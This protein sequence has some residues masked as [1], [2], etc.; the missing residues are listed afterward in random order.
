MKRTIVA[1]SLR[2]SL[3]ACGVAVVLVV[4]VDWSGRLLGHGPLE[5]LIPFVAVVLAAIGLGAVQPRIDRVVERITHHR[6]VTPY[7]S[8]AAAA[9]RVREGALE[10]ALPGL[11]QVI[12]DG[13]GATKAVVWLVVGD[14]L[15]AAAEHPAPAPGGRT[16]TVENLAVLL[17]RPDVDHAVPVLDGTVLRAALT[18]SKPG[19]P[20]TPGDQ[21]LVRDVANGAALLLR[22]VALNAELAERVRRADDLARE[23]HASRQRLSR[24]REVERR[25]LVAELG[26]ATSVRLAALRADVAAA[27]AELGHRPG[28]AAPVDPT[29]VDAEA[30]QRAL[31][32]ARVAL[33]ELLDR[34]RLIARGVF[35]AVLRDQGPAAALDE[36]ATDLP[37]PVRLT[38]DLGGRLDYEIESGV[39]YVVA[40]GLGALAGAP[41][42]DELLVDLERADGRVEVRVEDPAAAMSPDDLRAALADEA[43]RL[44]ALGGDLAITG[45]SA[46]G[47]VGGSVELRVRLPDRLEPIVD[48]SVGAELRVP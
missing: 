14:K 12:A 7:S 29:E 44:A 40:S 23:L 48:S 37:R 20:I 31:T 3:V 1:R 47:S 36:V 32:Q 42:D 41:G 35:P 39:Y 21:E 45:G 4:M 2:A 18:I 25:R 9:A 27:G 17:A 22:G 46:P 11:A 33:D 43:E 38:G 15:V 13:T 8:L 30:A 19:A 5:I 26:N 6:E 16:D 24:A 34:F 28:D 10:E